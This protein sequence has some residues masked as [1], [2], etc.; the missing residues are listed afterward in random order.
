[1]TALKVLVTVPP[2]EPV[3]SRLRDTPGVV[4]DFFDEPSA[5]AHGEIVNNWP[6]EKLQDADALFCSGVAPGNFADAKKI[7]WVQL[8]SAGYEQYIP[9]GLPARGIRASNALGTFD[10]PIGEWNIAMMI[11]LARDVRGMIRNQDTATWDRSPRFQREIRGSTVGFWGYGG[12]ARETARLCKNMGMT[13]YA[14]TRSGVAQRDDKYVVPGTGDPDGRYPDRVFKL[15]ERFEFLRTLDFLVMAMPLTH[16]SRGAVGEAELQA[17][18]RHACLLNPARGLLIQEQA[19]LKALREKWIAAAAID[20]H[21]HYPLSPDHPLW[22]MP[23]VILTPHISGS[24][25]TQ[26]YPQRVW[27]IFSQNLKRFVAGERLLNE[28]SA[29]QLR[30]E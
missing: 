26:T 18:P 16:A 6:I 19:L 28:L 1:M 10:V 30:G 2:Y 3:L 9:L 12:L 25:D 8:A 22:S 20:T 29:S 4:L 23:N 27:D 15:D 24:G 11:N 7:K 14:L 21:Y 13:V 17:L 5:G